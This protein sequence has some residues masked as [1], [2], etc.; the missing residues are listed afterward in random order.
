MH[1]NYISRRSVVIQEKSCIDFAYTN[2]PK[3]GSQQCTFRG[4]L[5]LFLQKMVKTG[6]QQKKSKCEFLKIRD[7]TEHTCNRFTNGDF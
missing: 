6:H 4:S 1:Y 2:L 7:P 5:I 3:I